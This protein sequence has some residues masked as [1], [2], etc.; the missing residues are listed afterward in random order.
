MTNTLLDTVLGT[1]FERPAKDG[2]PL[3]SRLEQQ[4]ERRDPSTGNAVSAL[5]AAFLLALGG[6]AHRASERARSLLEQ[7]PPRVSRELVDFYRRGVD[8][9][10]RELGETGV[11]GLR[12]GTDTGGDVE[13]LWSVVF[14]EGVG[15]LG[16]EE[17]RISELRARR[18]VSITRL[19]PQPI[20]N[21][22]REILFTSNVLLTVPAASTDIDVL[23]YP[24]E[25]RRQISD[26]AREILFHVQRAADGAPP[27]FLPLAGRRAR[28]IRGTDPAGGHRAARAAAS[29]RS[30]RVE[31]IL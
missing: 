24:E 8:W 17:E 7:P 11:T 26:P 25:L 6:P 31:P 4:M 20:S 1:L 28:G 23:P 16:R 2:E 13:A 9:I 19:N 3:A 18:K 12:S 10:G 21:P 15:I 29:N 27:T 22:A 14:P 5:N 30:L